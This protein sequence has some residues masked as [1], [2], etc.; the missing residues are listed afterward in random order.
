MAT[1]ESGTLVKISSNANRTSIED[2]QILLFAILSPP[3]T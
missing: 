1:A 2:L 3:K